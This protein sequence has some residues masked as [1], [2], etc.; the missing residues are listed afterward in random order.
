MT[1]IKLYTKKLDNSDYTIEVYIDEQDGKTYQSIRSLARLLNVS[2]SSIERRLKKLE[3]SVAQNGVINSE[4]PTAAGLRSVALISETIIIAIANY[5]AYDAG[6]YKTQAARSFKD[7]IDQAGLRAYH[8]TVAGYKF[9]VQPKV[10]AKSIPNYLPA[11]K[12]CMDRLRDHGAK[13]YTYAAVE[14]YNNQ[15][16]GMESKQRNNVT[17]YQAHGLIQNYLFGA[18]E[19]ETRKK[20]FANDQRHLQNTTKKAMRHGVYKM[21]GEDSVPEN[22]KPLRERKQLKSK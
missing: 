8:Y 22:L 16:N 15:L 7:A 13:G 9:N 20:G 2:P 21:K 19:L 5:Y 17:T 6:R 3:P 12:E 11:R 10:Q 1:S 4:V 18:L 14:T